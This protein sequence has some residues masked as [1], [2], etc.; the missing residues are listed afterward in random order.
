MT[1]SVYNKRM[2]RKQ[3]GDRAAQ[4]IECATKVFMGVGYRRAQIADIAR[5]MGVAPGTIYLYVE[6]KEA[7]FELVLQRAIAG[8]AFTFPAQRPVPSPEPGA[9][10]T[11]AT[12]VRTLDDLRTLNAA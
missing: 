5:E 4:L 9:L 11:H 8:D 6:S 3:T 7:L 1:H 10:L 2:A 12:Q